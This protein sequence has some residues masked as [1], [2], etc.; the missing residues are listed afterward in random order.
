MLDQHMVHSNKAIEA[1]TKY[2]ASQSSK[3]RDQDEHFLKLK[4]ENKELR[5]LMRERGVQLEVVEDKLRKLQELRDKFVRDDHS[6]HKIQTLERENST[7]HLQSQQ[8]LMQAQAMEAQLQMVR[9]ELKE[10]QRRYEDL[11]ARYVGLMGAGGPEGK[12]PHF[13]QIKN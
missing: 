13:I 6:H 8:Y 4:A 9:D 5:E 12:I 10:G 3:N 7:L 2:R 11:E 1:M